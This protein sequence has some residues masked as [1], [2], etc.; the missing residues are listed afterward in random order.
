MRACVF[1]CFAA[2]ATPPAANVVGVTVGAEKEPCVGEAA[3]LCL[4]VQEEGARSSTLFYDS[5]DGFEHA[6]GVEF[7]IR[8]DEQEVEDPPA[9]GS[10]ITWTHLATTRRNPRAPGDTFNWDVDFGRGA[11]VSLTDATSGTLMDGKAFT[12][13]ELVCGDL[14]RAEQASD[15]IELVF[16][17]ADP[18]DGPLILIATAE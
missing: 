5:I 14:D 18:I 7:E 15:M 6:W 13:D 10:S 8:V 1:L 4:V 2:C 16:E 9:D 3:Q 12:C 11:F 17:Y